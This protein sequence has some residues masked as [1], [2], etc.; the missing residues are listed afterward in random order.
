MTTRC[1]E[2]ICD[3]SSPK[4]RTSKYVYSE[5]EALKEVGKFAW[6]HGGFSSCTISDFRWRNYDRDYTDT[7]HQKDMWESKW[8]RKDYKP[9][10]EQ[11]KERQK[12]NNNN[13]N[14]KTV[15]NYYIMLW[16]MAKTCR[17]KDPEWWSVERRIGDTKTES[18]DHEVCKSWWLKPASLVR[19]AES[20]ILFAEEN[21]G[22]VSRKFIKQHCTTGTQ[23]L[24]SASQT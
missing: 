22:E 3:I 13:N 15:L 18:W 17:N 5:N 6:G 20:Y 12:V 1:Y 2:L 16:L 7:R 24:S 10:A 14:N 19:T 8:R 23:A 4:F 11:K 9:F 21:G